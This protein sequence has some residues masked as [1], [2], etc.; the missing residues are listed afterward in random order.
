[1][2]AVIVVPL[3]TLL[4]H[5]CIPTLRLAV[6]L[7]DVVKVMTLLLAWQVVLANVRLPK[8]TLPAIKVAVVLP[9]VTLLRLI[10]TVDMRLAQVPV[11]LGN[12]QPVVKSIS[13]VFN[14]IGI[15]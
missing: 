5:T 15:I 4:R 1:V 10:S 6:E 8:L 2:I 11:F 13:P 14:G 9:V 12:I 7:L 3:A